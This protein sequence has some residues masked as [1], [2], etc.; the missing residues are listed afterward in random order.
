[1][2]NK[3]RKIIP[4]R[5]RR[6]LRNEDL[7]YIFK[8][9]RFNVIFHVSSIIISF[10]VLWCFANFCNPVFY[11]TYLFILSITAFFSFLSVTGLGESLTQS[12]ANGYDYFYKIVIK[13]RLL[14]STFIYFVL[15][16]LL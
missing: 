10:I 6:Y 12:V 15:H 2:K 11:G 13:K 5:L 8:F 14:Y 4:K 16:I 9:S 1:M 3:I 7:E